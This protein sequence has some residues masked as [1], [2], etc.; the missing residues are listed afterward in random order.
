[1]GNQVAKDIYNG[2]AWLD[3]R[4]ARAIWLI[5]KVREADIRLNDVRKAHVQLQLDIRESWENRLAKDQEQYEALA[6]C[7]GNTSTTDSH[8]LKDKLLAWA[9]NENKELTRVPI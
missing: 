9:P 4:Q 2:S 7:H 5:L 6:K 8:T 3:M 1:M